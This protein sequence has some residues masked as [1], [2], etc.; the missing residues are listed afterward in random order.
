M[1]VFMFEIDTINYFKINAF[2]LARFDDFMLLI[3][4][5]ER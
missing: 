1:G 3:Q 4:V 2:L 5:Y